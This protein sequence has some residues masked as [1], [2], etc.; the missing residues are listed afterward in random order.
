MF[1]FKIE[2]ELILDKKKDL[3][4]KFENVLQSWHQFSVMQH[5]NRLRT[6]TY[7]DCVN[8]CTRKSVEMTGLSFFVL[9][10]KVNCALQV[11]ISVNDRKFYVDNG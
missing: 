4:R 10:C 8:D 3:V 5:S 1:I 9:I 11:I 6:T 2:I 7:Q